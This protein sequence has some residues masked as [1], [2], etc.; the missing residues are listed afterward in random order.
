M[1]GL[2]CGP[3]EGI[4]EVLLEKVTFQPW[5]EELKKASFYKAVA[6]G[7]LGEDMNP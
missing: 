1:E 3:A 4:N 2:R 7:F 6:G 5:P